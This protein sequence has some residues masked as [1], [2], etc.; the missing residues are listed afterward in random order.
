MATPNYEQIRSFGNVSEQLRQAAINEFMERINDNMT[1]DEI[2]E[3]AT[4]VA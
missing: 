1:L 3:Q 4:E 2:I